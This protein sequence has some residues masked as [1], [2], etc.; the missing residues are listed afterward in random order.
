MAI[1]IPN[2]FPTYFILDFKKI[3]FILTDNLYAD[4]LQHQ[5]IK[6]IDY[7]N[8][9]PS[10]GAITTINFKSVSNALEVKKNVLFLFKFIYSK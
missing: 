4:H 3:N 8:M 10:F 1:L 9:Y 6:I 7:M 2:K 5:N